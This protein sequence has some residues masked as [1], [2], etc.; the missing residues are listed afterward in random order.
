MF[1]VVRRWIRFSLLSETSLIVIAM[2]FASRSSNSIKRYK[3]KPHCP[4]ALRLRA[5]CQPSRSLFVRTGFL[6]T[7]QFLGV[8]TSLS[9]HCRRMYWT[10]LPN[11]YYSLVHSF[12]QLF[13]VPDTGWTHLKPS[14]NKS[15]NR[16][17]MKISLLSL[18]WI[19]NCSL[20]INCKH[21]ILIICVRSLKVDI[22]VLSVLISFHQSCWKVIL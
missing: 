17:L 10:S 20:G 7:H 3:G 13:V 8:N 15:P 21:L 22:S 2:S 14:W 9:I 6:Y 11:I 16:K 12:Q 18:Y 19:C 5:L 1:F 4:P